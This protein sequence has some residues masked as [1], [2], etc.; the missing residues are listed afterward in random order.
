MCVVRTFKGNTFSSKH[1]RKTLHNFKK[2][3]EICSTYK[4]KNK[5]DT[6]KLNKYYILNFSCKTKL[7]L[8]C[9]ELNNISVLRI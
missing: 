7:Q 6:N 1:V 8:Q 4:L 9:N 3:L 5:N 2:F